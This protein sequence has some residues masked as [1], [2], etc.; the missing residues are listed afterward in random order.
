[1][2]NYIVYG[3]NLRASASIPGLLALSTISSRA[4]DVDVWLGFM[5]KGFNHTHNVPQGTPWYIRKNL[6]ENGESYL[7]VWQIFDDTHFYLRYSDGT[8]FVIDREG[9]QI[10]ARSPDNLPPEDTATYLLG[11]VFGFTLRLRGVTCLHASAVVIDEQAVVFLGQ[12]GAGKST[13][14]AAFAQL[15]YPVLSDDVVALVDKV[16]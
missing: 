2:P 4:T 8:E 9:T 12:S 10:W 13:T 11:P 5:P 1:M 14:A 15:G 6:D 3:L 7:K 16:D